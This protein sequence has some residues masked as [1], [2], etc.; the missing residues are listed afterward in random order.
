[1]DTRDELSDK[2]DSSDVSD[3]RN[4]SAGTSA[5]SLNLRIGQNLRRIAEAA[6]WTSARLAA[7]LQISESRL[8]EI[9]AGRLRADGLLLVDAGYVLGVPPSAFFAEVRDH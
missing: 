7:A 8:L 6:G 5:A 2:S 1:M 3:G 9:E 4:G